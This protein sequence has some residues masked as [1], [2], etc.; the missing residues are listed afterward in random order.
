MKNHRL[1]L[2]RFFSWISFYPITNHRS[3]CLPLAASGGS[4]LVQCWAYAP[5]PKT[6]S[7]CAPRSSIWLNGAMVLSCTSMYFIDWV[8]SSKNG[9]SLLSLEVWIIGSISFTNSVCVFV[10]YNPVD[11][12]SY[13]TIDPWLGAIPLFSLTKFTLF[14]AICE[15]TLFWSI[16]LWLNLL[17]GLIWS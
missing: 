6:R 10:L 8:V 15:F 13:T 16:N 1:S 3:P 7:L 9:T 14:N 12:A 17:V 4:S 2:Y 11:P 5:C